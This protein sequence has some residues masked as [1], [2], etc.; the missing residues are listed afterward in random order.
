MRVVQIL[1]AAM[2]L[3]LA[4]GYAWSAMPPATAEPVASAAPASIKPTPE[5]IEHSA[6]YPNCAAVRAA[7]HAP[8]FKAQPGYRSELDADSDG[9]AC[10]PYRGR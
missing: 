8:I 2:T 7:G 3:G 4:A 6:Y 10:E 5:E 1:V 9:I